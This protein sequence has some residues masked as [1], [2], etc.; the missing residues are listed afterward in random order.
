MP[1][2]ESLIATPTVRVY[3]MAYFRRS[4]VKNSCLCRSSRMLG[5]MLSSSPVLAPPAEE[6]EIAVRDQA[7]LEKALQ[8]ERVGRRADRQAAVG[9]LQKPRQR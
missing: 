2:N 4:T 3:L 6:L 1:A 5:S 8:A 9:Q 7:L